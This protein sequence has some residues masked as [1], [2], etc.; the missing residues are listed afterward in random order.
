MAEN[1]EIQDMA[2][3]RYCGQGF[4]PIAHGGKLLRS[5]R[6]L[7]VRKIFKLVDK[8]DSTMREQLKLTPRKMTFAALTRIFIF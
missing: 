6:S 2:N 5:G 1:K 3:S 8:S 7:V 4:V